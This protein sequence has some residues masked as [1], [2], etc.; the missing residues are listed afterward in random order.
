MN[1]NQ[2]NNYNSQSLNNKNNSM[3]VKNKFFSQEFLN[4]ANV[5]D[6]GSSTSNNV[7][8]NVISWNVG[9]NR[10]KNIPK[11]SEMPILNSSNQSDY[12]QNML[13]DVNGVIYTNDQPEILDFD[14]DYNNVQIPNNQGYMNQ[15]NYNNNFAQNIVPNDVMMNQP[16]SMNSLGATPINNDEIPN[17]IIEHNKYIN[18]DQMNIKNTNIPNEKKVV[19]PSSVNVLDEQKIIIDDVALLKAYVGN[20]YNSINMSPFS[21]GAFFFNEFYF[22][23][24]KMYMLGFLIFILKVFVFLLLREILFLSFLVLIIISIILG[25]VTNSIYLGLNRSKVLRIKKKYSRCK[26]GELNAICAKKG[27]TSLLSAI[28]INLLLYFLLVVGIIS[29]YGKSFFIDIFNNLSEVFDKNNVENRFDGKVIYSNENIEKYFDIVVPT[30]FVKDNYAPF[31]YKV[32][33][34]DEG[35]N[36]TC[37][38]AFGIAKD[39]Y[40]G[41]ELIRKIAQY[42]ELEEN[43]T[44]VEG[45]DNLTWYIFYTNTKTENIFYRATSINDRAV[46][47]EYKSEIDAND[48]VCDRYIVEILDSIKLK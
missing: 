1:N 29:V 28:F 34:D 8:N 48:G 43:V 10:N 46:I 17:D 5:N 9:S 15:N 3:P 16:L 25:L 31:S 36:S 35:K 39:F 20:K 44:M 40:T 7:S 6:V 22:Y 27:G 38:F 4:D 26:Q 42:N 18:K 41:D 13:N 37:S 45:R 21:F 19:V 14:I 23:Y 12:S 2:N 30:E 32:A 33:I 11:A 47:F 24:R